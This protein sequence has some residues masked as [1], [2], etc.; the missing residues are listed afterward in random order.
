MTQYASSASA[1]PQGVLLQSRAS[2]LPPTSLCCHG[3]SLQT[4]Q[5]VV[6]NDGEPAKILR[7]LTITSA[8]YSTQG[9][10]LL[11]VRCCLVT[12]AECRLA[13]S[14]SKKQQQVC[15]HHANHLL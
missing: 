12:R 6:L 4:V 7:N 13:L 10:R 14:Y 15:L 3:L 11:E 9:Y 5:P 2:D 1:V 8:N